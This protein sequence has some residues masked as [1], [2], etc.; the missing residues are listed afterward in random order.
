MEI[1]KDKTKGNILIEIEKVLDGMLSELCLNYVVD[2]ANPEDTK[3]EEKPA[4]E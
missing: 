2:K 1:L 4:D 3:E